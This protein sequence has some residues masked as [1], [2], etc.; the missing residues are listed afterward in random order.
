MGIKEF[1]EE[2]VKLLTERLGDGQKVKAVEVQKNNGVV[3][4]GVNISEKERNIC[5]CIYVDGYYEGYKA[6]DLEIEEIVEDIIAD[7][8]EH[9]EEFDC[10]LFT[11]YE[12]SRPLLRGKLVNTEKNLEMLKGMPHREFLD[13]SLIYYVEICM[14]E[15]GI[16]SILVK[17]EHMEKW[18]RNEEELYRAVMENMENGSGGMV[19]KLMELIAQ[20]MEV[21]GL[22][23]EVDGKEVDLYVLTNKRRVNGAVYMMNKRMLREVFH[24]IGKDFLI[25]PSSIHEVLLV[26]VKEE[27]YEQKLAEFAEMVRTVNDTQLDATDI[28]SNHV[29]RYYAD[30]EE[31]AI[32]V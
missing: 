23:D 20:I 4:H 14:N 29:Y 2:I 19:K 22:P 7:S 12:K 28:L 10:T 6:G 27:K 9:V 1:T 25:L 26:P 5:P 16:G 11:E 18:E 30:K 24:M 21:E 15:R 32:E 13:L 8:E 17:N 31:V 3:W